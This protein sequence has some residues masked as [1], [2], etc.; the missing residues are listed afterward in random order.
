MNEGV[1]QYL[2]PATISSKKCQSILLTRNNRPPS[3]MGSYRLSIDQ[4]P[5]VQSVLAID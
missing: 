4:E 5:I 1:N 2:L 3:G